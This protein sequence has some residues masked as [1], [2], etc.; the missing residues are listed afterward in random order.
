[1]ILLTGSSGFLGKTI[2]AELQN[3]RLDV[4]TLGRSD[5]NTIKCDLSSKVP[6]IP[7]VDQ[8]IHVAGKAHVVP[9]S[10]GESKDFFDVN[11]QGTK[12]LLQSLENNRTLKQFIFIS[13]VAVYGLNEG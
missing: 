4:L 11:V 1:M 2:L 5:E 6:V 10:S 9:S 3:Q 12:N 7:F 8:V 13:S